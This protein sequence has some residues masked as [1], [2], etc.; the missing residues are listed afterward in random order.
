[1]EKSILKSSIKN[2]RNLNIPN[3]S[4]LLP[5]LPLVT[6]TV[7]LSIFIAASSIAQ[8]ASVDRWWPDAIEDAIKKGGTNQSELVAALRETP[9]GQRAGMKFLVE[10]MPQPDL[11][12]LSASFLRENVSLTYA[13]AEVKKNVNIPVITSHS[14]R[15]PDYCEKILAE[16][17]MSMTFWR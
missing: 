4:S 8:Q 11:E 5:K 17:S 1:M 3:Q 6:L 13:A 14:L 7:L 15:N 16:A 9:A 2:M 10:N 12:T